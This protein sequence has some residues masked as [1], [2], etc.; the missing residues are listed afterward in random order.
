MNNDMFNQK[1]N[2]KN[3]TKIIVLEI[4][5]CSILFFIFNVLLIHNTLLHW[6]YLVLLFAFPLTINIYLYINF[7]KVNSSQ[8]NDIAIIQMLVLLFCIKFLI[9]Q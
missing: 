2:S 5:F 1:G 6:I 3:F 4:A 9:G 7:K 8:C